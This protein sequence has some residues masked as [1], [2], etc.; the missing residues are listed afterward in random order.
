[1]ANICNRRDFTVAKGCIEVDRRR[2]KKGHIRNCSESRPGRIIRYLF[3]RYQVSLLKRVTP[4][5]VNAR[6]LVCPAT[7][8]ADDAQHNGRS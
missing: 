3:R 6:P 8:N 2:N 5:D 1:M 7:I 4:F